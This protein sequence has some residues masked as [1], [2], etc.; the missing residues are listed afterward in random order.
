LD[1]FISILDILGVRFH[2][3][4]G[5]FAEAAGAE[6][7]NIQIRYQKEHSAQPTWDAIKQR[8]ECLKRT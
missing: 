1:I 8:Y 5:Q 6:P 2:Y 3:Q 7:Q 4:Y